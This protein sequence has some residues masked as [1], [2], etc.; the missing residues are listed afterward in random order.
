MAFHTAL[1]TSLKELRKSIRALGISLFLCTGVIF[2]LSPQL[3]HFVQGHL[4]ETLYFFSV[5]GPFLAHVKLALFAAVYV[6]MPWMM[7][8]IWRALGVPFGV[9][10]NAGR[11]DEGLGWGATGPRAAQAYAD[12]AERW[13]D[14]GASV[15]GGCCGIGP[16]HIQALAE[17]FA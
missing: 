13:R 6:L 11:E 16:L 8:V 5:S 9:Y 17:R 1:I 2:F 7:T 12:I 4:A 10:A 14:A 3:L 15:I